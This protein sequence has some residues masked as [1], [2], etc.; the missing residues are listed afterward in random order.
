MPD[1]SRRVD[2]SKIKVDSEIGTPPTLIACAAVRRWTR[3][4]AL[5]P[6]RCYSPLGH[7]ESAEE[8]KECPNQGF[9]AKSEPFQ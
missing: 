3:G 9:E 6:L 1:M 5:R 2:T 4:L 8:R 7:S